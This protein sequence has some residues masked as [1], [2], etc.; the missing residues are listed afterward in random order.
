MT[1]DDY[2]RAVFFKHVRGTATPRGRALAP[3]ELE[4]LF[5]ACGAEMSVV[6]ARDAAAIALCYAAGLRRAEAAGLDVEAVDLRN[7]GAI[8]VTGKGGKP[9]TT[10]LGDAVVWV[11]QWLTV[12][13]AEP[14]PLLADVRNK[15]VTLRRITARAIHHIV[16]RRARQAGL[17]KTTPH[18]LRRTMA[19]EILE[20]RGDLV[21]VSRLLGHKSTDTTALYDRRGESSKIRAQRQLNVPL[22]GGPK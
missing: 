19:T 1:S 11:E 16:V 20:A 17:S 12:R 7:N 8:Q 5:R 2:Q 15:R 6:G 13:G 4:A 9:R 18:D 14:G 22:P 10:Y 3:R 21:D